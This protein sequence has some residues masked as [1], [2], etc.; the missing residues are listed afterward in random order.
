MADTRTTDIKIRTLE[1]SVAALRAEL[2]GQGS[3]LDAAVD[4]VVD[5]QAEVKSSVATL[6]SL[7]G[8]QH[9][10]VRHNGNDISLVHDPY[11]W[12]F[13]VFPNNIVRIYDGRIATSTGS[14]LWTEG[15]VDL[16]GKSAGT[17]WI[18]MTENGG[19]V[20]ASVEGPDVYPNLTGLNAAAVVEVVMTSTGLQSAKQLHHSDILSGSGGEFEYKRFRL[21]YVDGISV[22]VNA[23][24]YI[25]DGSNIFNKPDSPPITGPGVDWPY[26]AP[27]DG[28]SFAAGFV[29][30]TVYYVYLEKVSRA[31]ADDSATDFD[32]MLNP[33]RID[34]VCSDVNPAD[35]LHR[36]LYKLLGSFQVDVVTML[37]DP[38]TIVHNWIGD[39]S[40]MPI[41]PDA[42]NLGD[43]TYQPYIKSLDFN[44]RGV[45]VRQGFLQDYDAHG[46]IIIDEIG[47]YEHDIILPYYDFAA[48][49]VTIKDYMRLD[50]HN[51]DSR[52]GASEEWSGRSLEK[53]DGKQIAQVYGFSDGYPAIDITSVEEFA[54]GTLDKGYRV[55]VRDPQ[56]AA[57]GNEQ[58]LPTLKYASLKDISFIADFDTAAAE[59]WWHAWGEDPANDWIHEHKNHTFGTDDHGGNGESSPWGDTYINVQG[60]SARN[61]MSGVIGDSAELV[62]IDPDNRYLQDDDGLATVDWNACILSSPSTPSPVQVFSWNLAGWY[63]TFATGNTWTP[64]AFTVTVDGSIQFNPTGNIL[65]GADTGSTIANW[66]T[67]GGFIHATATTHRIRVTDADTGVEKDIEVIGVAI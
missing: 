60:D 8:D 32:P 7:T 65:F 17:Y 34:V 20:T 50:S 28:N 66:F 45:A 6:G 25:C 63:L 41:V 47:I 15:N 23:G 37:V 35:V 62:S 18:V 51:A 31:Q 19:V 36:R 46:R 27:G 48:G 13:K 56:P 26:Q 58:N 59:D 16:T 38:A 64:S 43:P 3:D 11:R 42:F 5:L 57:A 49:G 54:G 67:K 53:I 44:T 2:Q 55:L 1:A 22:M 39:V 61:A 10:R 21:D 4:A 24:T 30:G 52:K 33:Q 14:A 9:I 40:D 12:D 29:P